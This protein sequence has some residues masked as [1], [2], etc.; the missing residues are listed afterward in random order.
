[1]SNT[2][3]AMTHP[4]IVLAMIV[5]N[6]EDVLARCLASVKPLVSH[7]IIVD[8]GSTDRTREVAR[9]AMAGIP[10]EIVD[11][12]WK[13]FG[14]NR[15]E[16]LAL[17]RAHGDYTLVIDADDTL[18]LA[19]DFALPKLELDSYLVPIRYGSISYDRVQLL[20]ND[21]AWR[22]DGVIHEYPASS[23]AKTQGRIG[24][25][26]T[27]VISNDGARAKNPDRF[28]HDAE[29][30]EAALREEPDNRRYAFYLGQSYRDA[31]MPEEALAAYERRAAMGGWE[32]EVYNALYEAAR[33][34]ERLKQP[35][36][37]V[38][39]AYL[40]AYESRPRRAEALHDLARYCRFQKR[41]ALG[42]AYAL[43]ATQIPRP[44]DSLFVG[45]SVYAWRAKDELAVSAYHCGDLALARRLNEELLASGHLPPAERARIE[46]NLGW[47]VRA[48]A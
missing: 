10:G 6:E 19:P 29:L 13:N 46:D 22:Y 37:H 18:E 24:R 7:W 28:R 21:K 38:H 33:L 30:I 36:D 4:K 9:E 26:L 14:H 40:K 32:E 42:R 5:K 43:A 31:G 1:M 25:G 27:Y 48:A 12:P 15:S 44:D 2:V 47:C 20:K 35:F 23:S 16:A 3:K 8:T 34:R 39:A 11:R 17:A 41:F 45:D